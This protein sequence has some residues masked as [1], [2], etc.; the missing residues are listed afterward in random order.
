MVTN[1]YGTV[2]YNKKEA[3]WKGLLD[4]RRSLDVPWCVRGDFNEIRFEGER[5]REMLVDRFMRIFQ[6]LLINVV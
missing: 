1:V 2:L 3:F 4:I 6:K 5:K